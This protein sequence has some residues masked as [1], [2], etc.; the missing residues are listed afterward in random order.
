M[1]EK[2][3]G[4]VQGVQA[5]VKQLSDSLSSASME[6]I[7]KVLAGHAALLRSFKEAVFWAAGV[8]AASALVNVAVFALRAVR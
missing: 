1:A 6:G 2:T 8:V 4:Y 5:S 7:Q 3:D